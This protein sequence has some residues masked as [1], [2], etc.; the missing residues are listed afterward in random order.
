L[1]LNHSPTSASPEPSGA[2]AA[3]RLHAE[4]TRLAYRAAGSGLALYPVLT[5]VTAWGVWPAFPH[6]IILGWVFVS[7][8]V[9]AARI[10][11]QL[12]FQRQAPD[13]A[14]MPRWRTLFEL[15]AAASGL[16]WGYAGWTFLAT[17]ETVPRL[18]V[19]TL[20]C[21][22]NAGAARALAPVPRVALFFTL[23]TLPPIVVRYLQLPE[24]SGWMPAF[25][26][27][28]FTGFLVNMIRQEYHDILKIQRLIAENSQLVV[29]LSAAKERAEAAN[30]AKSEFIATM[31]HEIRTPMNGVIGML[32][33][34]RSSSLTEDQLEQ[35]TIASNSAETLL[36]LLNDILD[37]S[38]IE[39]GRM[40]FEQIEFNPVEV[41]REVVA[42]LGSRAQEKRLSFGTT[43]APG[44][45]PRVMGDLIRV[46]QVLI[47][48]CGNAIKFTDR[49]GVDL[50]LSAT[51]EGAQ[52]R[53]GFAVR[54]TGIGITPEALKRLFQPFM[55]AD[56][57]TVR[58]FGGTGLGLA[59]SQRLVTGMGGELRVQ[60][61]PGSGSEFSFE[62]V[63]PVATPAAAAPAAATACDTARPLAGRVLV[64]EDDR[65]N[66]RVIAL[67]LKRLGVTFGTAD[68]GVKAT[69][70]AVSGAWDVVLMD[71]QMP[72]V[73]GLEAARRIRAVHDS[74]ALPIIALTANV[75]ASDRA[76]CAEAGMNDFL[77]KPIR[78]EELRLCLERWLP[79]PGSRGRPAGEQANSGLTPMAPS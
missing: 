34:L 7:V 12:A 33:V 29:T 8:A 67:M 28:C 65:I 51:P 14:S 56:S 48:L 11:L 3:Q 42:L 25:V 61:I 2:P 54:D 78:Q 40:E 49:G 10:W 4:T 30:R 63:M 39:S 38:K 22:L 58:R 64:A 41:C 21:G 55:Q 50:R 20:A 16:V 15:G 75:M 18:L 32:Q 76:A 35:I 45:P 62:L 1:N 70:M 36:V 53:L 57:S 60:S 72:E 66:Q 5:L 31:S 6:E 46:R 69:E 68:D 26:T 79:V 23:I 74:R 17:E 71:M 27:L 47:N 73:D 9:T 24:A 77:T 19:L 52:V 43:V 13:D 44:V 59:I 37:L